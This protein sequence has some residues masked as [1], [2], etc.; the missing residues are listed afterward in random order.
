[1][2]KA[3]VLQGRRE[4]GEA[5]RLLD[6]ISEAGA[7]GSFRTVERLAPQIERL[8]DEEQLAACRS[9]Q[10]RLRTAKGNNR[11]LAL[12]IG[13]NYVRPVP[14]EAESLLVGAIVSVINTDEYEPTLIRA[15]VAAARHL[16]NERWGTILESVLGRF[17][18]RVAEQQSCQETRL[19]VLN[20]LKDLDT[21]V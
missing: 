11:R 9:I 10:W 8:G 5:R 18:Q 15:A 13:L 3:E 7:R 17:G 16:N 4:K 20:P 12:M 21:I 1:M 6:A 14:G 19:R 2:K